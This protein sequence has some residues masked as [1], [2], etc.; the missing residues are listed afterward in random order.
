MFAENK[1]GFEGS[2]Y[3]NGYR[4]YV[5]RAAEPTDIYWENLSIKLSERVKLSFFTYLVTG[6]L[7]GVAF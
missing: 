7:I 4:V 1:D 3:F 2:K 5:E 6:A